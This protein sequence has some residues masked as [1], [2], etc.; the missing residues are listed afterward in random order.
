MNM[1]DIGF[2]KT[3]PNRT[4]LETQKTENSVSA[5]RF[6]KTDFGSLGTAFHIVSFTVHLQT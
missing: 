5:I 1:S 6:L 2:L 4:D 3:V